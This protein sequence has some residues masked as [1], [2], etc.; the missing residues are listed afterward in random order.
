VRTKDGGAVALNPV[1]QENALPGDPDWRSGDS[2]EWDA[3]GVYVSSESA[4][5]GD[6]V[7]VYVSSS[8]GDTGITEVFRLGHYGGAGARR[9]WS[10][11]PLSLRP[12]PA[13]PPQPGT[14]LVECDWRPTTAFTVAQ[15]WLSGVYVVRVRRGDGA[16]AFTPFVVRDGRRA[17]LLLQTTFTTDQ[18]YNGWNGESLYQDRTGLMPSGRAT[19]V[20]FDRPYFDAAGLGRFAWRT[21]DFVQF[22]E[23]AG[24]DVTYASNLDFLRD[25]HL[26]ERVGALVIPGHDEYWP[27]EERAAVDAAVARGTS[28]VYFGANGGYWRIRLAPDA[29]G[30]PLRTILCFKG[31]DGDPQPGSTVRYR[32]P[33]GAQPENQLFGIMYGSY[34]AVPFP[35]WV[36][37][38]ESWMFEGTGVHAGDRFLNLVG[39]EFDHRQDNGLTPPGLD[40][41]GVS[42]VVSA[43]GV[44]SS[45]EF[46]TRDLPDG[47]VVFS[48]GSIDW[49]AGLSMDPAVHDA[50]VER[51]VRNVLERA[52]AHWRPPLSLPPVTGPVPSEPEPDGAWARAVEPFAGTVGVPG[53]VDGPGATAR[54]SGPTGI[55]LTPD[56]SIV[57]SEVVGQRLRL[58]ANDAAHTVSTLAG[59]GTPGAYDGAGTAATFRNPVA[60]AVD[61][62]GAVYVADSGNHRIRRVDPG[63]RHQVSTVTGGADGFADGPLATARFR[64]PIALAFAADGA[65]LVVDELDARIRRVDLRAKQVTTLAGDGQWG[66]RDAARG[67]DARF[68]FPS[69]IAVTAAG[70]VLVTDAINSAVRRIG[71]SPPSPVTTLVGGFGRFGF[72]DGDGATALLRA[73]FGAA[74]TPD[75][76][77]IL[78]D[79]ANFRL[80]EVTLGWD[81]G[82]TRVRTLAGSGRLGHLLGD[83]SQSDLVTPAGLAALPD[84]S[85]VVS[86]PWNQVVRRVVR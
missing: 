2:A 71:R 85:V 10:S 55:A 53:D 31:T 27:R 25:G 1:A 63:P 28:L 29:Q 7:Q 77:L 56:G 12:Q 78:G 13:C 62:I 67:G 68:Q 80:R 19:M 51:I 47:G 46:V 30:Q 84:G 41:A 57:V 59:S 15:S 43:E 5:A 38:P 37:E 81:R 8:P 18:A 24:Y 34:L 76:L 16:R 52:L 86:D 49:T 14:A 26:L 3:L 66:F 23:R 21:L 11:D 44:P 64:L 17:E 50:R 20:S 9:V 82:S 73:Q 4:R 79:T 83:G 75:G 32:D 42:P 54:F 33:P 48:A 61:R 60:V 65:L 74:V 6:V 36:A 35:F 58:I 72:A 69:A 45:S 40:V 22:V 70:D 39:T